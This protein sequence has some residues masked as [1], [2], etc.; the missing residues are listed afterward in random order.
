MLDVSIRSDP[1]PPP[2]RCLVPAQP[3]YRTILLPSYPPTILSLSPRPLTP[4]W[5][6]YLLSLRCLT[7]QLL[8]YSAKLPHCLNQSAIGTS[9]DLV[10]LRRSMNTAV[11]WLTACFEQ[12]WCVYDS[13]SVWNL[14]LTI[15]N[16]SMRD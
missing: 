12:E 14:K 1:A 5:G 6:C 4:L 8:S 3:L 11:A 13:L 15:Q 10:P 7:S 9:T 16:P 2:H